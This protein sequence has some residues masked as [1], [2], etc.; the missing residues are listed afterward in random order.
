MVFK[1]AS[2]PRF[3]RNSR[4]VALD[5]IK[6]GSEAWRSARRVLVD[7]QLSEERK[8]LGIGFDGD[9]FTFGALRYAVLDHA[10]AY[11]KKTPLEVNA[12][13]AEALELA[14]I[15]LSTFSTLPGNTGFS[16]ISVVTAEFV[17]GMNVFRDLFAAIRDV[18]GGRSNASEKVLKDLKQTCLRELKEEAYKVGADAVLGV[19]LDYSEFS[20]GG[21]SMLLPVASGTAV[22]IVDTEEE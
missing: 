15:S 2:Q 3:V 16:I 14:T 4:V 20:G 13:A 8:S 17:F 22:K 6:A 12:E 1:E 7:E 21:K 9:K 11:V 18:V 19:D 5:G 10:L